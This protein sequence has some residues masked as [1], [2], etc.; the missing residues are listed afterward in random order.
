M[1]SFPVEKDNSAKNDSFKEHLKGNSPTT[2][3]EISLYRKQP[4]YERHAGVSSQDEGSGEGSDCTPSSKPNLEVFKSYDDNLYCASEYGSLPENIL[5]RP[6]SPTDS[7]LSIPDDSPSIQGSFVSSIGGRSLP[8]SIASRSGLGSPTPSL[9]RF[10]VRFQSR[11]SRTNLSASRLSAS[12]VKTHV[13]DVISNED[14]YHFEN[15]GSPLPPWDIVRWTKLRKIGAQAFSEVGKRNFG[16]PTCFSVS[17]SIVLGTSKGIILIFDYHQNLKSVIGP[18]SKAVESGPLT[19]IAISADHL[20][21]AGGHANGAIFTWEISRPARSFLHIPS[22]DS[23]QVT[24][25]TLDGHMPNIAVRHLG[26]L[27]TRH[28]ALVSADDHGM[29]FS[30]LATRGLG[31]VGRTVKTTRILGRYPNNIS[32]N[33]KPRKPSTVL[34]F[35]PLPLGNVERYTDTLGLTAILTPHLLVIVSTTPVA[36]TQYKIAKLK[37]LS[38]QSSLSGCLA[39]FPAVKLNSSDPK[40]NI[41]FS[42]VKLIYCWSNILKVLEIEEIESPDR[43]QS[44]SFKSRNRWVAEE[45]IVAVQWL[46]E[47][48]LTVLTVTQRLII[49]EDCSMRVI[50]TFDLIHKHIYHQDLFSKHLLTLVEGI[51]GEESNT[52]GSIADAFYM[53]FK[54]YKGRMFLLSFDDVSVGTLPKWTDRIFV[55]IENGDFVTAIRLGTSYYSGNAEKIITGLPQDAELRH[56]MVR[57]EL[58]KA[59]RTSLKRVLHQNQELHTDDTRYRKDL[60]EACIEACICMGDYVFLFDEVFESFEE[61]QSAEIFIMALEPQILDDRITSIPTAVIKNIITYFANERHQSRVDKIICHVEWS[62]LDI[63]QVVTLCK[64]YKLYDALISVWNRAFLDYITPL[65]ELMNLLALLS[66]EDKLSINRDVAENHILSVNAFKMFPYMS[67]TFTGRAYPTGEDLDEKKART[68]KAQLYWFLFS[69]GKI[70]WPKISG[71]PITFQPSQEDEP[72]FPYLRMILMFDA[73]S[74][75]SVLNEAFE[76]SFLNDY[77]EHDINNYDLSEEDAFGTTVN[78][79]YIITI[80]LEVMNPDEFATVD[81][82]YLNMFIARNLPKFPQFVL[83]SSST[84][85]KVLLGLCNYPDQDISDDAQLSAE[86]LLSVYRPSD[87]QSFLSLFQKVGFYRV[88][89]GIYKS[90]AQW[91]RLLQAYFDDP[92]DQQSIFDCISDYLRPGSGLTRRQI[93]EVHQVLKAHIVDLV[94]LDA[95]KMA[96]IINLYAPEL[97]K[98]FLDGLAE[99]PELMYIYLRTIFEFETIN[100]GEPKI[101]S[102]AALTEKYVQLMCKFDPSRVAAFVETVQV[103]DLRLDE[104]LPYMEENGTIDAAVILITR[105]GQLTEAMRRLI[106]HMK[107]LESILLGIFSGST[108]ISRLI[109]IEESVKDLLETLKKYTNVG[110]WLCKN[111]SRRQSQLPARRESLPIPE[112]LPEETLWLD[113]IETTVQITQNLLTSFQYLNNMTSDN[114]REM[115]LAQI[116][117]PVQSA[118]TAL[119]ASTTTSS[120]SGTSLSFIRILRAFLTRASISSPSL[121]D[122][123][124]VLTSVFSAYTYE[125][126]ILSLVNRLLE[127]NLFINVQTAIGLRQRGWKPSNSVC[128]ECDQRVWGPGVTGD[129]YSKWEEREDLD[130]RR[131]K[132]R[133]SE[134]AGGYIERGK[135]RARLQHIGGGAAELDRKQNLPG[136]SNIESDTT[137]F[138]SHENWQIAAKQNLDLGPLIVLACGHTYHQTC[139][140]NLQEESA[141][142]KCPIDG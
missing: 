125:E 64:Q 103:S 73:P 117:T 31:V 69:G 127:K 20:V 89:K 26:F 111:Q 94:H 120:T 51:D 46:S 33:R 65:V 96:Q 30:H 76:D 133:R 121:S 95:V 16:T 80:L 139:L 97:H 122:L 8:P 123:R 71:K 61:K 67:Y 23:T 136:S 101:L 135:G 108:N 19:S 42:K 53:S 56:T 11:L 62:S 142:L 92:N 129:I 59:M 126:S 13:Q 14:R 27:G 57:D 74:F 124:S 81:T 49:L 55:L 90:E 77:P 119:L 36:Q 78:R 17:S 70:S 85:R 68:A 32:T 43:P 106:K 86:Y 84:L 45:S 1:K 40:N 137:E 47:S 15:T 22:L 105:H 41:N 132:E 25:R 2:S 38:T 63:D 24:K 88:L 48:V 7:F 18:G 79:Q 4:V 140:E 58:L 102:H 91:S 128:G 112:S 134:L 110:I 98:I 115:I 130:F 21:V 83:L 44:L 54:A 6:S 113:F 100:L 104:V 138:P 118:F 82:I 60:A 141:D 35:A 28:T 107:R 93:R 5:Q 12:N 66:Q 50:G 72:S 29:A 39:W 10:D 114:Q 75:L 99:E 9:R 3:A 34:G 87:I 131:R 37:D 116:R 52:Y 109:N